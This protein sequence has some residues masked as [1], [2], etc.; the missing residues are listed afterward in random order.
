MTTT[1]RINSNVCFHPFLLAGLQTC[2]ILTFLHTFCNKPCLPLLFNN[3][4]I[5]LND[6]PRVARNI[7]T[8]K[9]LHCYSLTFPVC[10]HAILQLTSAIP[11]PETLNRMISDTR[12]SDGQHEIRYLTIILFVISVIGTNTSS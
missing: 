2:Q 1:F 8:K 12:D 4:K 7:P 10:C 11:F 9:T 5:H 6:T 3:I